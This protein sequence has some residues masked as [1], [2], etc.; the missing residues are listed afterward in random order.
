MSHQDHPHY[1]ITYRVNM[2]TNSQLT[3]NPAYAIQAS[4]DYLTTQTGPLGSGGAGNW[5]GKLKFTIDDMDDM[6]KVLKAGRNFHNP[7]EAN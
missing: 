2:T 5:V 3:A 7:I 4:Q 1:G 6:L